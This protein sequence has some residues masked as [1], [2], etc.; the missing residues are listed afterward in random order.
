MLKN[1]L[2]E[3]ALSFGPDGFELR[4]GLPW[5]RSMPLSSIRGLSVS[6][7]GWSPAEG[8]LRVRLGQRAIP[9]D[10]LAGESGWWFIQDRLVILFPVNRFRDRSGNVRKVS[11]DFE[12]IVP[13]LRGG[14]DGPLVLPFHLEAMLQA[15]QVVPRGVSLD[16]A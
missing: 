1:A 4:L 8:E 16:V 6:V 14:A 3:D 7:D 13:Y 12:L 11:V 15:S 9:A 5:I 10:A 2:R